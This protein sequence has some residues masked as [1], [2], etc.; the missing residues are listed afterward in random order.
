MVVTTC[1]AF[2][3]VFTFGFTF[4]IIRAHAARRQ[5]VTTVFSHVRPLWSKHVRTVSSDCHCLVWSEA[6][7][8]RVNSCHWPIRSEPPAYTEYGD[9]RPVWSEVTMVACPCMQDV[10]SVCTSHIGI[11]GAALSIP[12]TVI[13]TYCTP[14]PQSHQTHSRAVRRHM[15]D[16]KQLTDTK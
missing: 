6:R 15:L 1:F 3:L 10:I 13:Q 4:V 12:P 2:T 7:G 16:T 14:I 8:R 9:N 5:N 11:G